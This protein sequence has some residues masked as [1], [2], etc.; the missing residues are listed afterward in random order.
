MYV[1]RTCWCVVCVCV[2]ACVYACM[3]ACMQLMDA[4][5]DC[6][7]VFDVV[8]VRVLNITCLLRTVCVLFKYE[9]NGMK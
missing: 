2:C 5:M 3:Y 4:C 7:V 6:N 9:C 8:A 1:L